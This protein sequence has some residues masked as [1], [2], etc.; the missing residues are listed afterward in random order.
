MKPQEIVINYKN[1]KIEFD[2]NKEEWVGYLGF[3]DWQ[4]EFKRHTSL[5]KLKEAIDRFNKKEFKSIPILYFDRH[6]IKSAE[7][8]SFTNVPGECWIKK[9]DDTREKI[10]TLKSEKSYSFTKIYAC[11]NRANEPALLNILELDKEILNLENELEQKKKNKIHLI[12]SL[13]IFDIRGYATTEEN[14]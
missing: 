4:N 6:N 11:E 13:E 8:I 7:I 2:T 14:D 1:S 5:K 10:L 9:P 12:D 3:N